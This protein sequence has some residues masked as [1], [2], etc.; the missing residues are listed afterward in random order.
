[1]NIEMPH[2]EIPDTISPQ[3]EPPPQESPQQEMPQQEIPKPQK[4]KRQSSL[5]YRMFKTICILVVII[6]ILL[7]LIFMFGLGGGNGSFLPGGKGI[8]SIGELDNADDNGKNTKIE[9]DK[10]KPQQ[11]EPEQIETPAD[12]PNKIEP[13]EI[14]DNNENIPLRFELIISFQSDLVNPDNVKEFACNIE[15]INTSKHSIN[16]NNQK[17]IV[18]ENMM[19]FEFT[20][21]KEFRDWRLEFDLIDMKATDSEVVPVLN[22][23]MT[24]FPGE[25]V[26]R[27]IESIVRSVDPK[28]S[29]MRSEN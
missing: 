20:L 8:V 22:V 24:P 26:F 1:M 25:G 13:P 10:P 28:I 4:P 12:D 11:N 21:E 6:I 15:K 27:K 5:V 14:Q 19:E 7:Y 23:K 29:I 2:P 17:S 3:Q 9:N 18:C 16:Q